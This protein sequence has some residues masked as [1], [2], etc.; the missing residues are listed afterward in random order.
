MSPAGR[1]KR[2]LHL[3]LSARTILGVL[4]LTIVLSGVSMLIGARIHNIRQVRQYETDTWELARTIALMMDNADAV[5]YIG[6][7][8]DIYESIPSEIKEDIEWKERILENRLDGRGKEYTDEEVDQAIEDYSGAMGEFSARFDGV[9]TPA[10]FEAE[11]VLPAVARENEVFSIHIFIID[12][13][14]ELEVSVFYALRDSSYKNGLDAAGDISEYHK[15][16]AD[17]VKGG[18]QGRFSI[19]YGA[20]R[21]RGAYFSSIAPY[22]H[23]DTGE[24]IAYV[25]VVDS[26]DYVAIDL[27]KF[28]RQYLLTI[29][30]AA[31]ILALIAYRITRTLMV[32]PIRLM[33]KA[34][35]AYTADTARSQTAAQIGTYFSELNIRTGD[36]IESLADA[37]KRMEEELSS[38]V[39]RLTKVTAQTERIDT[40]LSIASGI[41]E[42]LLPKTFPPFPEHHEFDLYASMLP[43]RE[44]GGD[45]YDLYLIDDD[46]LAL[47]IADVSGKGVPASLFMALSK[48]MLKDRTLLGGTPAAILEDVNLRL[49]EG[50]DSNMFCTVWLG[51]LTLSTGHLVCANAGHENPALRRS[52]MPFA[53]L[54]SRHSPMIGVLEQI[55]C[56]DEHYDLEPGD[57]LFL[58]TDGLTEAVGPDRS[59]FTENR[60]IYTLNQLDKDDAPGQIIAKVTER[61][62]AFME[63]AEQYDDMTSL[64][65]VYHG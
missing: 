46:H 11:S 53:P 6:Q 25:E 17:Y 7:V 56:T 16:F 36:E 29:F 26:Y 34:A 49:I 50:N 5:K 61:I 20:S 40:E 41:Q 27:E 54:V 58:Y 21:M 12:P 18:S 3:S 9:A 63:G 59:Q 8:R 2:A 62:E 64:C 14:R 13:I 44:V 10:F 23:P 57:V 60:L 33:S 31:G 19:S 45:F 55:T 15:G 37:M 51:I 28:V 42:S 52:G 65:L 30:L 1:K 43:A 22:Y 4:L 47:T 32:N 24:I 39:S 38:Y 48:T 35:N